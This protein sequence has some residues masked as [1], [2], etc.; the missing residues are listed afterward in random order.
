MPD[1]LKMEKLVVML[2]K[3][4]NTLNKLSENLATSMDKMTD[5]LAKTQGTIEHM[6]QSVDSLS[7]RTSTAIEDMNG[8]FDKLITTLV[9]LSKDSPLLN[10]RGMVSSAKDMVAD[11]LKR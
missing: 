1:L 2:E 6:A 3:T 4:V 8:K 9:N 7:Q 11:F 5:T 10:P